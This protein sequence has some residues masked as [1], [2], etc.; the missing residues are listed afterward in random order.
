M[1]SPDSRAPRAERRPKWYLLYYLL[2]ALDLVTVLASLTLSHLMMR[3]YVDSVATSQRWERREE[4]YA[5]LFLLA[6]AVNAPGNDVF[7]S[8]DLDAERTRLFVA[9][10]AFDAQFDA[11]RTEIERDVDGA[12]AAVLLQA[13]DDIHGA[14]REM[15]SEAQL[16]FGYFEAGQADLAGER[17]A[18]MD[19]KYA[20]FNEAM[21]R[22]FAS[23]RSIRHVHFD[24][25]V[26]AAGVLKR[27]EYLIVGL[28]ILMVAGA[29]CYGARLYRAARVADAERSGHME[30][31]ARARAAADEASRAKSRFLA[32]MSHEIRTPL[33]TMF[34]A[35]DLLEHPAPDNEQ[36]SYLAMARSSGR[37]LK[38]LIEDVLDLSKIELGKVEFE[39][40][41][42]D[43]HGLLR[44]L[45]APY[46][47]RAELNGVTLALR[48]A[49]DVPAAVEGDPTRF[50][51]IV[52]NLVDNA[53][54]FTPTGSIEVSIS[55]RAEQP[56]TAE[57]A[58]ARTVPLHV[59][60]RDTGI[61]VTPE[62][63]A[64][65]FDDFVQADESTSRKY[66]GTGLGLGIVRRLVG[67]MNGE[68]GV[69]PAPGG[70]S[71]F[72]CDLDLCTTGCGLPP[73]P[74]QA[75]ASGRRE[76]LAG[77]RI[78]LVEDVPE[79]RVLTAAVLRQLGASVDLAADGAE[80]ASAAGAN[81]YDAILMDIAMPR[82][83][84]FEATRRIR[85]REHGGEEVPIIALTAH[86]MDGMF[87]QCL[88]AGMDDYLAKPVTRD[89]VVA[90]LRRWIEL[91]RVVS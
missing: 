31:L 73:R 68:L 49:P 89:Q 15:V 38:R 24:R 42:F 78:L 36:R 58:G 45:L 46:V 57:E 4:N 70:G 63:Q 56:Y 74:L 86:V 23:V 66:G 69:R 43:L 11:S 17:M 87:E 41:R 20:S 81:R 67:L 26:E 35:L 85:E 40:V 53:V 3:I 64:R 84:G 65:I 51:Q 16:I 82:M 25:Q 60:V 91:E 32:V 48:I 75:P 83:D 88:D 71:I 52:A 19:R 8:H 77:L 54:K 22:L 18:T 44:D 76:S 2:A 30:A 62:Q 34:L 61:G 28:A 50:G 9:L 29:L 21:A 12:E 27:L 1:A 80:A 72:W 5:R 90:A 6:R 55:R 79:S 7:D 10:S 13:F 37:S 14:M 47:R 33:N 59:A 39:C